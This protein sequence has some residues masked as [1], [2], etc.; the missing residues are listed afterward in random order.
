MSNIYTSLRN[1]QAEL[2]APKSQ[3][4]SFG[5]YNY[6]NAEDI[7]EAVKPLLVKHNLTMTITDD[8]VFVGER[9]YIKATVSLFDEE[10]IEVR[11]SAFAREEETKKGMDSSQITGSASSYARKYALNG[12]FAIDDTKDSDTTNT[13]GKEE[14][15]KLITVEQSKELREAYKG[16]EDKL[17][18]YLD[19]VGLDKLGD[20]LE[21]DARQLLD[22][23]NARKPKTEVQKEPQ[24][25]IDEV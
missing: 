18:T 16:R 20:M 4:N 14:K 6:R 21:E 19:K 13:H 5:K 15:P 3:F 17:A 11:V 22:L 8:I 9:Y 1:I 25:S 2:K 12:M 23:I 24:L 10:L 7:L